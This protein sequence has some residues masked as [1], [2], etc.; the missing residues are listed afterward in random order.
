[1]PLILIYGSSYR[2]VRAFQLCDLAW[3]SSLW[4][5]KICS[6]DQIFF[7]TFQFEV[8]KVDFWHRFWVFLDSKNGLGVFQIWSL[9]S[10]SVTRQ[11]NFNRIKNG[12]KCQKWS[13]WR[14]IL[15]KLLLNSVTRQVNFNRT[16]SGG[17]SH[18]SNATF[19]GDFQTMWQVSRQVLDRN[20]D[21]FSLFSA[22]LLG[23]WFEMCFS[24]PFH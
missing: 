9:Q 8:S 3:K 16:K 5:T 10:N 14:K 18:N 21:F 20:S 7:I 4:L 23:L 1:M 15:F 24:T 12:G 22:S 2:F 11:V 6:T 19:L 13:I 17:K